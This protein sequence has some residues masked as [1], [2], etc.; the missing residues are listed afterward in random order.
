MCSFQSCTVKSSG[1]KRPPAAVVEKDAA[2]RRPD[3]QVAEDLAAGDMDQAG[4]AAENLPLRPFAA[5][6]SAEK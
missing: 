1:T 5:A 6:G 3:A 2:Q 4:N